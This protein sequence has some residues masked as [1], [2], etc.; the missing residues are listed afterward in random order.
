MLRKSVGDR[1]DGGNCR[2]RVDHRN[3]DRRG[4]DRWDG[5]GKRN[6]I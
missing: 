6:S 5:G 1:R 4:G 3:D 2:G